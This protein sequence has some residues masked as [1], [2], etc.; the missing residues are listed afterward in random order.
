[1]P[2]DGLITL[3]SRYPARDTMDRLLAALAK[4]NMTG[5]ARIDHAAGAARTPLF[6]TPLCS[7]KFNTC[8]PKLYCF[9]LAVV[10][11]KPIVYPTR[12]GA[13]SD[14]AHPPLRS[15][16]VSSRSGC[17]GM[18]VTECYVI[19]YEVADS[20]QSWGTSAFGKQGDFPKKQGGD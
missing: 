8:R 9:C 13:S 10:T 17:T 16:Y 3:S 12:L 15:P 19:M 6:V 20:L 4:R 11:V 14:V 2:Q 1:M 7:T 18:R 5:F